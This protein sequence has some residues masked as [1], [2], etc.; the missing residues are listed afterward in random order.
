MIDMGKP[1]REPIITDKGLEKY[2]GDKK[3]II[4]IL[5]EL[6]ERG[7]LMRFNDPETCYALKTK[8][9]KIIPL[10]RGI[11]RVVINPSQKSL[12]AGRTSPYI[13]EYYD[14]ISD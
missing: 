14:P 13:Y 6:A 11:T 3:F 1:I 9:R 8:E 7:I 5:G 10:I 4:K 2:V 12:D